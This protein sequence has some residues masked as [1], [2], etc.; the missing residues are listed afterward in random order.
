MDWNGKEMEAADVS[1]WDGQ[2]VLA[3]MVEL[4]ELSVSLMGHINS[5]WKTDAL[6][7]GFGG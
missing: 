5:F 1:D 2:G 6:R 3:L 4:S 7:S